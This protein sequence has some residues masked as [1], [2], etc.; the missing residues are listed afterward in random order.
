M[1]SKRQVIKYITSSFQ[2]VFI[3]CVQTFVPLKK[4]DLHFSEGGNNPFGNKWQ[5][6]YVPLILVSG[7]VSL[8]VH[9][10]RCQERISL[11]VELSIEN[12]W[13]SSYDI[14]IICLH[15]RSSLAYRVGVFFFFFS[16]GLNI[17]Q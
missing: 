9:K 2:K 8:A 13:H 16:F 4:K 1:E 10:H 6:M 11:S 14:C 5:E 3:K 7:I 15:A 12:C 17:N